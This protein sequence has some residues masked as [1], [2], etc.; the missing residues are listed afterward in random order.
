[1]NKKIIPIVTIVL[2]LGLFVFILGV[3][4]KENITKAQ[5][6]ELYEQRR[7]LAVRQEQLERELEAL[8]E[9]YEKS[10]APNAFVQVLFTEL[11]EQVYTQC[12]PIMKEYEYTGTLAVSETQFPGNE[13]CMSVEQFR[14]LIDAGWEICINWQTDRSVKKWWPTLRNKLTVLG[15]EPGQVVYF[16]LGTYQAE[17]DATIQELGFSIAVISKMDEETPLQLQYEEGIWH[18]GAVGLMSPRPR[19]WLNEAVAQDANMSYLVGFQIEEELYNEKSFRSMLNCFDEYVV[20]EEL[21]VTNLADAKEHYRGR[22]LGV[23]P[24]QES[25]YREQKAA[26]EKELSEVKEQLKEIDAKY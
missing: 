9:V 16:P 14:E 26:L 8:Q 20:T 4:K 22:S 24:E 18:V 1:M 12:Y 2:A 5:H 19:L 11:N 13:G 17:L 15:V 7:P 10:K 3:Q 23:T 25:Q 6:D 21:I